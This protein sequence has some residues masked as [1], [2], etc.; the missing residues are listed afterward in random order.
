M[1]KI[2]IA[3]PDPGSRESLRQ[4][5]DDRGHEVT[6]ADDAASAVR[7]L[8]DGDVDLLLCDTDLPD[9]PGL[10][11]LAS[12]RADRPE[13]VVILTT[14][15]GSVEDA[16][17]AMR[18]G[19][20]DFLR[21]PFRGDQ[22]QVAVDRALER[23][24][25]VRENRD[26]RQALDD[27]VRIDN[28]IG[29]DRRMQAI[30][31]TIKAVADTRTTVLVTGESGTGKTVIA[32][33]LHAMSSRRNGP[34]VEVNC[35]ALPET[36]LESELF[37]HVKGAFTGATRDKQGKFEAADG[38][39]IFLDEI[40]TSSQAF[41]VRLLRVLQDRV[42]ERVGDNRTL[43]TDVRIVLATNL[44]LEE[45]VRDGRFR[46]DLYYRINVVAI[47]MPPLRQRPDDVPALALHFLRRFAGD[48]GRAAVRFAPAAMDLLQLARWP[49]NVRQLENVVER[50]VVFSQGPVIEAAD[51]PSNLVLR[52]AAGPAPL[53][54]A[55][56]TDAADPPLQ[57]R[58][59]LSHA[60]RR[61]LEQA[62]QHCDGNR[63]RAAK[64]LGINRSTLFA[65]LRRHGVR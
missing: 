12:V 52:D 45:A 8:A 7:A 61:I 58:E 14:A 32:R 60:E 50:A 59:A 41:Q 39:T 48:H 34:F 37:G 9:R 56:L 33:A 16:V 30:F 36:L 65:K 13:L 47:E 26:L 38:G 3:D 24:S 43:E 62:L 1:A 10:E 54:A 49:G 28:L 18:D 53:S 22:V 23:A 44:D 27:R 31:K 46:E 21:K 40:G 64:V 17:R 57:L 63:E 11:L 55:Q 15:F 19:A 29:E 4:L 2:L 35:G 5:F 51:L 25:L 42:V 6:L 20:A